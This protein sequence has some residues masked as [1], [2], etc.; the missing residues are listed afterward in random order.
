MAAVKRIR[1][2]MFLNQDLRHYHVTTHIST[3]QF[4]GGFLGG[5]RHEPFRQMSFSGGRKELSEDVKS[6]IMRFYDID[7]VNGV[8]LDIFKIEIERSPAYEWEEIEDAIIAV[9][10]ELALW[11][12][13]DVEMDYLFLG[14]NYSEPITQEMYDAECERQEE[15]ERRAERMYSGF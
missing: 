7:G 15:A 10:K 11:T 8:G 13:S 4:H 14:K 5:N 2:E 9:I 1:T 3:E 12:E 6:T